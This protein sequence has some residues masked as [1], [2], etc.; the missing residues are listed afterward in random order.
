MRKNWIEHEKKT[1]S[2]DANETADRKSDGWS[3]DSITGS[4]V[5]STER[6]QA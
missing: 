4:F 5:R 3:I 2:V 6:V 1:Q